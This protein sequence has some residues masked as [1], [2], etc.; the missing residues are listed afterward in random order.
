MT[1]NGHVW[2]G[3][4]C[5]TRKKLKTFLFHIFQKKVWSKWVDG[6]LERAARSKNFIGF[7]KDE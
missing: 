2:G 1:Q 5:S 3:G 6:I 7:G 4:G